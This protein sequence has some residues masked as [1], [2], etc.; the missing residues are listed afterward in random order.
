M[1]GQKVPLFKGPCSVIHTAANRG[2]PF[3]KQLDWLMGR[4]REAEHIQDITLQPISVG[5]D[6]KIHLLS[7]PEQNERQ[8]YLGVVTGPGK[9]FI[10]SQ[11]HYQ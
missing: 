5:G 3:T 10:S 9:F 8:A 11:E 1:N 2:C 4:Y 7:L 6:S